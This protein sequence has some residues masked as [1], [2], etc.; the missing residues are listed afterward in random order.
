MTLWPWPKQAGPTSPNF[1]W[2]EELLAADSPGTRSVTLSWVAVP[3][4]KVNPTQH[5]ASHFISGSEQHPFNLFKELP[6]VNHLGPSGDSLSSLRRMGGLW[7]LP[8]HL[9]RESG[10]QEGSSEYSHSSFSL[11]RKVTTRG[12]NL[13]H[14][15]SLTSF[16]ITQTQPFLLLRGRQDIK[17]SPL[18]F[19]Y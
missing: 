4:E 1:G 11:T 2:H 9:A 13:L 15:L 10:G 8:H 19:G 18:D 6:Q 12:S 16:G 7:G 14:P 17:D 3:R 5:R